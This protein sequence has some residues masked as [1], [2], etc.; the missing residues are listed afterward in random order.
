MS[1]PGTLAILSLAGGLAGLHAATWGAHKDLPYEGF[2][3]RRCARSVLLGVVS[4]WV[5]ISVFR[6]PDR[7][8]GLLLRLGAMYAVERLATEW[9]K[10]IVR[11]D[12]QSRY[13]IPMRFAI[14]GVPV[15]HTGVRYTIGA[16]VLVAVSMLAFSLD[17]ASQPLLRLG[18]HGG[19]PW[20]IMLAGSAGGWATAVGGAWKDAPIEGFSGWKFLRSPAVALAWATP[21]TLL[22]DNV[23]LV[24]LAA[25]GYAVASIE[26]YKTFLTQGRP[27]GKFAGQPRPHHRPLLRRGLATTHAG[28][29]VV[30]AGTVLVRVPLLGGSATLRAA[31]DWSY[32][33]Y[34]LQTIAVASVLLAGAVLGSGALARPEPSAAPRPEHDH[35]DWTLAR[36]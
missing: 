19:W 21:M 30:L 8:G 5:V 7:P 11:Q 13:T 10:A 16:G 3:L 6:L 15:T 26:T 34:A 28:L 35:R 20:L 24:S 9:W 29:W 17:Q 14:R 25:A 12:D 33:H 2:H 1:T 22:T 32:Q 23:L 18:T 27:P 36:Q 31:P 4:A